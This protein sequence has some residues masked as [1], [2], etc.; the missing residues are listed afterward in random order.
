[1]SEKC[2]CG[3]GA[4]RHYEFDDADR[5]AFRELIDR[6]YPT[7]PPILHAGCFH[8]HTDQSGRVL[9]CECKEWRTMAEQGALL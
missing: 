3:H 7:I 6:Q 9:V 2:R 4:D 8:N 5:V 1:M